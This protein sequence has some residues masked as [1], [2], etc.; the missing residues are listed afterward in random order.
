MGRAVE[1]GVSVI[2][3][4][5]RVEGCRRMRTLGLRAGDATGFRRTRFWPYCSCAGEVG[6]NE[7]AVGEEVDAGLAAVGEDCDAGLGPAVRVV[8]VVRGP[9]VVVVVVVVVVVKVDGPAA[10]AEATGVIVGNGSVSLCGRALLAL[11]IR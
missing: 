7:G 11:S 3:V 1:V 9:E 10:E 8:T 6:L 4:I 2:E 5:E